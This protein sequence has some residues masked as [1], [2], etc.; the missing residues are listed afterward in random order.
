MK[1]IVMTENTRNLAAE[2]AIG[3]IRHDQPTQSVEK[4]YKQMDRLA[5]LFPEY[6]QKAIFEMISD[7]PEVV[8]ATQ[9]HEHLANNGSR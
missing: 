5:S 9:I 8:T 4:T 7:H 6:T 2:I 1:P 3:F